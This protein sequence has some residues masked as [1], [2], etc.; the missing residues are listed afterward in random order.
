MTAVVKRD[1]GV[2]A[3][4]RAKMRMVRHGEIMFVPVDEPEGVTQVASGREYIAGHSESGHH[5][6]VTSSD[7]EVYEKDGV[8]F[9]KM[10]EPGQVKHLK[11]G[12]DK[13]ETKT[14]AKGW[15]E[16]R[17]KNEFDYFANMLREVRD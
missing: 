15:F 13:H 7:F 11:T 3:L 17:A 10:K 6:V 14:L 9:V 12:P 2:D 16:I 8:R 4:R 1:K 5:H